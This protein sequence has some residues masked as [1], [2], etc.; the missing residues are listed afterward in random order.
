MSVTSDD[1]GFKVTTHFR[2]RI[3]CVTV[4]CPEPVGG[5]KRK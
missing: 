4:G 5:S 3:R 2:L 1:A